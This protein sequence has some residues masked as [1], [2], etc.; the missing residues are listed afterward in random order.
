MVL[1]YLELFPNPSLGLARKLGDP[2]RSPRGIDSESAGNWMMYFKSSV[3][4]HT[5]SAGTNVTF[6]IYS[7]PPY[8]VVW[9]HGHP[10]V[11][12]SSEHLVLVGPRVRG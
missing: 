5:V 9:V 1:N 2:G 12:A 7:I 3:L 4:V 6:G 8:Q 11:V 10:V